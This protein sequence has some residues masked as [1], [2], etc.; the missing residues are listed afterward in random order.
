PTAIAC[1]EALSSPLFSTRNI[2]TDSGHALR[3]L[4][5][6]RT[7]L[8]PTPPSFCSRGFFT[9]LAEKE[10]CLYRLTVKLLRE[11]PGFSRNS[12]DETL[13]SD[14]LGHCG[15]STVRPIC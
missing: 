12:S 14:I 6:V 4:R 7:V 15:T 1:D 3:V 5:K 9:C 13:P 11:G 2:A 8:P 10:L